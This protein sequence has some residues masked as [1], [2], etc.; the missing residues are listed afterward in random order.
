MKRRNA[1][2]LE[3]CHYHFCFAFAP[4]LRVEEN[5][6]GLRSGRNTRQQLA[7]LHV[8]ARFLLN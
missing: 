7:I 6:A 2:I 1:I 5:E 8:H 3:L 4:M